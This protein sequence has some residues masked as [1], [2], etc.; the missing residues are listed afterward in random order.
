VESIH[1]LVVNRKFLPRE[2]SA[3]LWRE[4]CLVAC[5]LFYGGF[6][7]FAIWRLF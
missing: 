6:L 2:L 7:S 4:A 3:P 5:A 1:T